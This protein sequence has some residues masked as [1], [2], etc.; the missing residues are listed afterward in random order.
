MTKS[1]LLATAIGLGLLMSCHG[2]DS[3]GGDPDAGVPAAGTPPAVVT[4]G[5]DFDFGKAEFFETFN[6]AFPG[7]NW[8]VVNGA[9]DIY[10]FEG[11]PAPALGFGMGVPTQIESTFTFSTAGPMVLSFYLSIPFITAE[12]A[13]FEFRLEPGAA[14]RVSLGE[15]AVHAE[16]G[17][18]HARLD[19]AASGNFH[20]I[21][22]SVDENG[23]ATWTIDGLDVL[24]APDFASGS[25]RIEMRSFDEGGARFVV[26]NIAIS[27]P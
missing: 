21:R 20:F 2:D 14:F 15:G 25:S 12:M 24:S 11:D 8:I 16:I 10:G 3:D 19:Y 4:P 23:T 6:G 26:D 13:D 27:R 5:T 9:P 18:L 17:D 1:A 7:A 22:F